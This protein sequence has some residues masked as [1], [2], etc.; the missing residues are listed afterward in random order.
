M[1]K[2]PKGNKSIPDYTAHSV[3]DTYVEG[4][5]LSQ[6]MAIGRLPP[7][8][9]LSFARQLL[10]AL[11]AAHSEGVVYEDLKPSNILIDESGNLF[12]MAFGAA[13]PIEAQAHT[14]IIGGT[15][16][17]MAPELFEGKTIDHRAN[18]YSFGLI[19]YEMVTGTVPF[20]GETVYQLRY[21]HRNE[22]P[23]DPRVVLSR[24]SSVSCTN[25]PQMPGE[26]SRETLSKRTGDF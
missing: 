7:E 15:L 17:Y 26:G 12:V 21:L 6:L 24:A 25:Y 19:L 1:P 5:N 8:R 2:V 4:E 10:S 11:D 3:G 18:I 14:L 20:K 22:R 16:D 9:V 13:G 23:A